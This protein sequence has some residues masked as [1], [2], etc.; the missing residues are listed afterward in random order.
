MAL[1]PGDLPQHDSVNNSSFY[2]NYSYQSTSF[3]NYFQP[4]SQV[5]PSTSATVHE[6][7]LHF[8]ENSVNPN[9]G[10][11]NYSNYYENLS[12]FYNETQNS[13]LSNEANF[14]NSFSN[15]AANPFDYDIDEQN[16]PPSP[17]QLAAGTSDQNKRKVGKKNLSDETRKKILKAYTDSKLSPTEISKLFDMPRTTIST[18]LNR[19]KND[20][21]IVAKSKGGDK[22]SKL[23]DRMKL[24]LREWVDNDS[25]ITLKK[26]KL[27]ILQEFHELDS[28]GTTT[29]DRAL[30]D[31]HYSFKRVSIVPVKRNDESTLNRRFVYAKDFLEAEQHGDHRF[32]FVDETGFKV[33]MRSKYGRSPIG[34]PVNKIVRDIRTLNY[35][36]CSAMSKYGVIYSRKQSCA[37]DTESFCEFFEVLFTKLE[38]RGL[39]NA[40]IVMDNVAFHKTEAARAIVAKWNHTAMFLPPYSPF[41]NPIENLFS[42]WKHLVASQNPQNEEHLTSLIKWA[43]REIMPEHCSNYYTNMKRYIDKSLN[44][45][46]IY[47]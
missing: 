19:W 22:R 18:I 42:Q 27:N 23:T 43:V 24:K 3:V 26:L 21:V 38:K 20:G 1:P 14:N 32:V 2:Q 37:F 25:S 4:D 7:A 47:N 45:E 44:Y 11:Y 28:I 39:V 9:Q 34:Q 33:C 17:P 15:Y 36:V 30:K 16:V 40:V 12:Q 29:I 6:P 31:F 41:L 8:D 10:Y 35:S 13:V 46:V 5:N